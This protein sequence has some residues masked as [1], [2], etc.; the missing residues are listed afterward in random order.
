VNRRQLIKYGIGAGGGV[1]LAGCTDAG[2]IGSGG[3]DTGQ[4]EQVSDSELGPEE[5]VRRFVRAVEAG[6]RESVDALVHSSGDL[7]GRV[8]EY[9]RAGSS[10]EFDAVRTALVAQADGRAFVDVDA[11]GRDEDGS[12]TTIDTVYELRPEDGGWRL[13]ADPGRV[14]LRYRVENVNPARSYETTIG[15]SEG[16]AEEFFDATDVTA[17]DLRERDG[18]SIVALSFSGERAERIQ[19]TAAGLGDDLSAAN[20]FEYLGGDLTQPVEVSQGL[21]R[22]MRSGQWAADPRFVRSYRDGEL[23]ARVAATVLEAVEG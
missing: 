3:Q 8:D 4:G 13:Y 9:V 7:A 2:G 1:V 17:V 23:A 5:T 15:L 6:E 16:A 12:T 14:P 20:V 11:E 10:V 21:A 19:E 18:R 22:R